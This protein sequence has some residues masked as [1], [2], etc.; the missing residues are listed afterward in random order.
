MP[1]QPFKNKTISFYPEELEAKQMYKL[2]IGS[3][4]PRPI[5]WISTISKEGINNLAPFSFFT[6]ASRQ[7][8]TLLVSIGPGVQE[9]RGTIKDTLTNIRDTEE[10]VINIVPE[11]LADAMH[12]S[13]M[14]VEPEVDEFVRAGL[15]PEASEKIAAPALK[16]SPIAFECKLD[17]IIPVGSDHLVLGEIVKARFSDDIYLGNYKTDIDNWKP[18]ARLAGDYASLSPSFRLPKN[19]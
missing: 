9:R 4:V 13:S 8:P 16:E 5:A 3:V 14:H 19:K 7:P 1:E 15:T 12:E 6:V 2:L 17:Q 10:Y 11:A 18:L